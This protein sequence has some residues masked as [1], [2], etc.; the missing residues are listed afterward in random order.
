MAPGSSARVSSR[1]TS[2]CIEGFRGVRDELSLDL[3][4]S[5]VLIFGPNGTGK[6]SVFDAI[7]WLLIGDV[8]RL[9]SYT[10][11]KNEEYL[12]SRYRL[13]EPG[14]VSATFRLAER[15]VEVARSG[16]ARGTTLEVLV[17]GSHH[18]GSDAEGE[19]QRLLVGSGFPLAELLSTSGMLQ[20]DDLKQLLQT[21]PDERYRQLLRL[22][23]LEVLEQFDRFASSR[24]DKAR[25]DSRAARELVD[26]LASERDRLSETLETARE[27]ATRS[28]DVRVD[29]ARVV[30]AANRLQDAIRI[31]SL[32]DSPE[33]FAAFAASVRSGALHLEREFRALAEMPS[34]LPADPSREL[35]ELEQEIRRVEEA[36]E[37]AEVS[38]ENAQRSLD[39]AKAAEDAVGR[40]ASAAL[41]LLRS[42]KPA[43]VCPVCG[44]S[45][46]ADHVAAELEAR[47][48]GGAAVASADQVVGAARKA[49]ESQSRAVGELKQRRD[50]LVAEARL[51]EQGHVDLA[52]RLS[53]VQAIVGRL[54]DVGVQVDLQVPAASNGGIQDEIYQLVGAVARDGASRP[55]KVIEALVSIA[56]EAE[57]EASAAGSA[58]LAAERA[59]SLPR[60]EALL[61]EVEERLAA[62]VELYE[63]ARRAETNAVLLASSATTAAAETFRERFSALSPLMN[64][65]YSRLDPHPAFTQLDFKVETYRARGTATASV[66]DVDENV[67]ANPMLVFSSA[68]A[69]AV[70]LAAFLAL[71]WAAG[72]RGLPFVLL[73][74][75]LQALDDVNVLGFADLARRIRRQRQLVLATH[76]ERFATLLERK[77]VGRMA[78][79][80][81]IVHEFTSWTRGGPSVETRRVAPRPDLSL[82]VLQAS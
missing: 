9:S 81:L 20:Q 34:E 57:A 76:E 12:L 53:A 39:A 74:D 29:G 21:R 16:S 15:E 46:R 28:S 65:I 67:E 43:E 3:D 45:I 17:D 79:D 68:Q 55:A 47:A 35:E 78:D 70:V 22:L 48:A 38:M 41:P 32:P 23:G 27:Q 7:Q 60:Q 11:R 44:Q 72:D 31:A 54:S 58:K 2:I 19:L 73:D 6:T 36:L 4:A 64:D 5:A 18:V 13:S 59:A 26:R 82:R 10:L 62:Q 51:R 71:S 37:A 69:N 33:G 52:A 63:R 40:L 80:D 1:I 24:K 25:A 49:L 56:D 61:Q 8:P 42:S 66:L 14:K 77:L 30:S 75:P 50:S